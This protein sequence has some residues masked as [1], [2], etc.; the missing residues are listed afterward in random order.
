MLPVFEACGPFYRWQV[1][2]A[3]DQLRGALRVREVLRD[4]IAEDER[5]GRTGEVVGVLG[6]S[7][8]AR[9]AAGLLA[10]REA[11]E[12]G[13]VARLRVGVF[14]CG[15][16]PPYSLAAA[17]KVGGGWKPERVDKH[18]EVR[19][20]EEGE[21]IRCPSV[22]VRGLM[23][24]HLEKGRRLAEWFDEKVEF[25][26]EMGHHLPGAAGDTTSPKDATKEIAEAILSQ[27]RLGQMINKEKEAASEM[28]TETN[29]RQ[30]GI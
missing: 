10:D 4:A 12:R 24:V 22:H 5:A 29:G 18:G 7:Q 16:Y 3:E 20:V 8:G 26:Y 25:E 23:D 13:W 27:F 21:V 2:E 6:F 1:P 28:K 14:V 17:R 15:S 9:M 19:E 30:I 11:G